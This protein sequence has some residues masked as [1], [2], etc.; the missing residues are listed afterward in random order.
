MTHA[1]EA[2]ALGVSIGGAQLIAAAT[3]RAG[4]G[5]RIAV[6]GPNGAGKSSLLRAL[7]GAIAPSHG[8][9]R[10]NGADAFRM[11]SRDRAI[12]LA[13]LPQSRETAWSITTEALVALGRFAYGGP[14][15]LSGADRA[16]VDRAL[17]DA[18]IAHLRERRV[19]ALSGGEAA[20]AHL[21]RA[22]AAQTP[23]LVVDEPTAALDPRHALQATS[24]LA[25]RA[26][27]GA[28][29]VAAMHDIDLALRFASRVVLVERGRITADHPLADF[30]ERALEAA[31]GGRAARDGLRFALE[32]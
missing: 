28:L 14:S 1:L 8:H 19:D 12:A 15:R 29:V 25:A 24:I 10:I 21:A 18:D 4:P 20:R 31:F 26:A 16:A 27:Q 5:E 32:K 30:P 3:L 2:E 7:A 23:I 9:T 22:L 13:Y 11:P 6:I 17:A